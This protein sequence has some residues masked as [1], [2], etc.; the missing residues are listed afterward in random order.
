MPYLSEA[1]F[2]LRSQLNG[3][4]DQTK[5]RNLKLTVLQIKEQTVLIYWIRNQ[6]LIQTVY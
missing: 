1:E 5:A 4:Q 3:W 2:I 6:T